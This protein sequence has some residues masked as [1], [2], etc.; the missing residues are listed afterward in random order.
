MNP[1][2]PLNRRAFLQRSATLA[3]TSLL[4]SRLSPL[5]HAGAPATGMRS[6][7]DRSP[8]RIWPGAEYW[9]NPH[10]DWR[11]AGGRAECLNAAPDRNLHLLTRQL[12]NRAG[13]VDLRVTI[14]RVGG[15]PLAGAGSAG[16][17]IGILGT[18]KD[19][20][21]LHDYRNNLW[22]APAAGFS[23]G[24]A[25]DGTLFLG[26]RG[27][28]AGTKVDLNREAVEL[29]LAVAPK[30]GAYEAS[31]SAHDPASGR[32]L[33]QATL[34]GISG[35]QL[36][37][38]IALECNFAEAGDGAANA[39]GRVRAKAKGKGAATPGSGP[40]LGSFWF[41]DWQVS[42]SKLTGGD[43]QVFGPILWSQYTLS[44]G[45]MK[46]SA[47]MP[48][49]G[50]NDSDTL[51]LQLRDG[52][53]WKTV[54][55]EKIHPEARVAAFRVEPWDDTR[56]TPYRL[57]YTLRSRDGG[58][59]EHYWTG[60]VRRDPVEQ[61]SLSVADVSCNIHAI[62]PNVPLV[63][64]MAQLNPDL[65]AFVGDQFY[66]STAG[67]GVQRAP[68][69]AAMLD[70]LRKWYFHGWTWRE[71]MRDR[72]S[73]SIPDDHD[74]YQG[75][76]WGEGGEGQKTTQEA[77]GYNMSAAWVNVVHRTQT[78][79]HPDPYD[80]QPA[81]RGTINYYGPMTYG[82]VSFAILADRQFKSGPEGKVPPTGDR[83]DHVKDPNWDPKTADVPGV[84]LLGSKQE[85]FIREWA[86]DWRGA[87]LK[88]VISQTIFTAMATT[89]GGNHEVLMVDY[90]TNGWAQSPRNRALRE[91]RKAFA[92]HIAGDQHLPAVVH[93]GIDTHRDGP[94]AFAGPAVN[95]GYQRWW[96]PTKTGRNKTTGNP[97]LT[98]DFLDHLGS[99]LTVLAV[100][101]G[102]PVPPKAALESVNAKT[103]G[104]G[105]VRL[106]KAKRSITF[107]CWPY[108][109]DV[110]Q[111][112]TQMPT[113]PVT[114]TQLD[115][116]ARRP[117]AHL[118]TLQV[119]GAKS[120]V[121]LVYEEK[122]GDLVYGLRL[123]EPTFRPHVFALGR[124]RLKVG[125]PETGTWQTLPGIEAVA[126]NQTT[127]NVQL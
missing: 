21:E 55:E 111:P 80:T 40:G 9:A 8:D 73:I 34:A 23:A 64:S 49:L 33:A 108:S 91:I 30:G 32:Q 65:L 69:D 26:R 82:R 12:A 120:P 103:S 51:R 17:R 87:D 92:V 2:A 14:G 5:L 24:F 122:T 97:N 85:Q 36:V 102:P 10:Q 43:D 125:V 38:N 74:V 123:L 28:P 52:A 79:H 81:K 35:D 115:N 48:P 75:N 50:P 119:S 71:L 118:P 98:G 106:N 7:W 96:E 53:D 1:A 89:H 19:Y 4:A 44:G 46:L 22:S 116:Y 84:D 105:L 63:Q 83:G 67:Y 109:A 16:F 25:A 57:A 127:L 66:E 93:Y 39:K 107:E 104:L 77:G 56:A 20:P 58:N 86:A 110:T 27:G 13:T 78:S 124:Y 112:G 99:P 41:A 60:T 54:R 42:G 6:A 45:V 62:F 70:Y 90:D 94:V 113:W 121:L 100:K 18:L 11:I 61:E 114:V 59:T 72:P 126:G 29:R 3:A 15:G 76:L 95:V 47:Q 31:L 101:N 37:G 117:A 88:A 68:L